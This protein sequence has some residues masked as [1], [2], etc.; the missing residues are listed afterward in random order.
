MRPVYLTIGCPLCAIA[1]VVAFLLC[2]PLMYALHI[3]M[4][5]YA[6]Q[7]CMYVHVLHIYW[8]VSILYVYMYV[9]VLLVYVCRLSS[10]MSVGWFR[11]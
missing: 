10:S 11:I 1:E 3:Y 8:Y 4:Y 9:C 7:I 5:V 2:G 6:F